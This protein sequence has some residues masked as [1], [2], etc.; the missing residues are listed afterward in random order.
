[1]I[2]PV[3]LL[4]VVSFGWGE[5]LQ[6]SADWREV[7]YRGHTRYTVLA[8]DPGPVLHARSHDGNSALFHRVPRDARPG[9]LAWRWRVLRHP[10]GADTR[11]RAGDDR[12]AAVFVLVRRGL[13]PGRAQGVLYQWASAGAP[14]EERPS[15]YAPNVRVITLRSTPAGPNWV[16][17]RRDLAAD[18]RR[19]FGAIPSRI[20]AIGVLCDTDDTG[21][22]AEAEFGEL[23]WTP[24]SDPDSVR[25]GSPARPGLSGTS[26]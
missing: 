18:L 6:I 25:A 7:S 13:W 26:R 1:M 12:A 17:E 15:P 20:E 16:D 8:G 10:R 2:V 3:W 22:D 21:D 19:I 24:P 9:E 4:A 14:I 23:R 5:R 11:T